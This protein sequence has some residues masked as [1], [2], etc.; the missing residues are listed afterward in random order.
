M[1]GV[2][3]NAALS[4]FEMDTDGDV[5]FARYRREGGSIVITHVET[6]AALRGHGVASN[7]M[8]GALGLIRRDGSK[9]V[10]AC[11]F[12][13]AYLAEHPEYSDLKP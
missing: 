1:S 7:L 5:A 13:R 12:A 11:S 4:R 2:R 6:P 8:E 3:D 9:V 10:A